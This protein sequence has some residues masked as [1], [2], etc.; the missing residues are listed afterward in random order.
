M[1]LVVCVDK[2]NGML[3]NNR[4]QSRDRMLIHHILNLIGDKKIW[5]NSYSEN[6]FRFK[7][8]YN[9]FEENFDEIGAEDY[10]FIENISPKSFE[11]Q[12]DEIII[13]NWNKIYPADMYFD[14]CLDEWMLKS[15][16][17]FEGFSHE[18]ITQKIYTRRITNEKESEENIQEK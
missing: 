16:I 15:E 8:E 3:F 6:L 9:L 18:K 7:T 4:R 2:N 10:C 12:I 13:Y 1:K 14:I 11:E 5:I 17:E